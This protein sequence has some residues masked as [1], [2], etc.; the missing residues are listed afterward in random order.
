[1]G[2]VVARGPICQLF[3]GKDL[4]SASALQALLQMRRTEGDTEAMKTAA[5]DSQTAPV[6]KS[7]QRSDPKMASDDEGSDQAG[8]SN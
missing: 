8:Q 3:Y 5:H 4:G 7:L 2:G 6:L 1:M